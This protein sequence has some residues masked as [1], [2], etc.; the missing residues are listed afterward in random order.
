[1]FS[2]LVFLIILSVLVLVHEFGHFFAARATGV[3]AE[4][5]GYGFPPR[6]A[7]I[8]KEKRGWKIV[9]PRD[10][11]RFERTIWSLNWLPLGGF[12]RLKGEEGDRAHEQDSFAAKSAP[13]RLVI[14]VAGVAMNWLLAAIIFTI[15]FGIGIPAAL[16]EIPPGATIR[17]QSV[18]IMEVVS[19]SSAEVAGVSPGDFLRSIDGVPVLQAKEAQAQLVKDANAGRA[20]TLELTRKRE[21]ITKNISPA[22]LKE[23]HRAGF[24]IAV[25]DTGIIRFPWPQAIGRGFATAAQFTRLIVIGLFDTIRHLIVRHETPSGVSGPVGIAVMTG[26]IA[27]QGWWAVIQ[28]TALL[29]L[30]L[31]IVNALPIPALDGG[32]M[33]FIIIES[34]R[35]RRANPRFEALA[36]R[37][38]FILL[39]LIIFTVTFYDLRRSGGVI[40]SGLRHLVGI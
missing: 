39:I 37:I 12:V 27:E 6:L 33:L 10:R 35:R 9:G 3:K 7:G 8:V 31:A 34:F 16:D 36:H 26:K 22:F 21:R 28:F 14:L 2:L 11:T 24:G 1:M 5:F 17:D 40:V 18:Q 13:R 30:N 38:G 32:R 29:S 4:E 19:G 15:G 25:A 20:A 23:L